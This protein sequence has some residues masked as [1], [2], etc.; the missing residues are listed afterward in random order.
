M[1]AVFPPAESF[2]DTRPAWNFSW[3]TPTRCRLI[4]ALVL[5]AGILGHINYLHHSPADLSGDEAQ[6]WDWSRN[7]D[8]SYYSKGPLVALIIRASTSIFGNTMPAVRYPA[9]A[10]GVATSIITYLLTKK[11]FNSE[12][13]ALG[14]VLLNHLV[15]MFI[16][17]SIL[18]TIDPPMFLCWALATYFAAIAL[19][20]N[21]N[22]PHAGGERSAAPG[23]SPY[24]P[25][26]LVGTAMGLGF[27]AKYAA[28]LWYLGLILFLILNHS[29]TRHLKGLLTAL[30]I[31][32]LFTTPVIIWNAQHHWVSLHHVAH[33]TGAAGGS[34]KKGN[35]LELIA[36]QIGVIGPILAVMMFAAILHTFRQ[37][38]PHS[39]PREGRGGVRGETS[40]DN[41]S[42]SSPNLPQLLYLTSL[43][44]TFLTLTLLISFFTKVQ[45][46]W[47]APAYFTLLILTAHF[48][49]TRLH[50][51]QTWRPWR[52]WFYG[53]IAMA[54]IATP[55]LHDPSL[56]FSP[57]RKTNTLLGTKID[58]AL[59]DVI[60]KL[61]GWQTLGNHL[62]TELAKHPD[63]II[64]TDDYMQAAE[65][66]FYTNGQP[67]TYYAGSYY[68]EAKRFTQYDMWPDRDL[69]RPELKG[70]TVIFL[71]KGGPFPPDIQNAFKEVKPL[72]DLDIIVRGVKVK[73]FRTWIC[74]NFKGMTRPSGPSSF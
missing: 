2:T 59:I 57:I 39:S 3:L 72:P 5:L 30:L 20:P 11:L 36:S 15:P 44:L 32:A 45:V 49:A 71:G 48:L 6:Y 60:Y 18:M 51:K 74:T 53:T 63:A 17:G 43:G 10:L 29:L 12:R 9:I 4:L 28:P 73:T 22:P 31:T 58:P 35:F 7:L 46:N 25:W 37:P 69:A 19:F 55:I 47:P 65:A 16:A 27:L 8:W 62:S 54:L 40:T 50:S 68:A 61:R 42:T 23:R 21:H 1:T 64:L 26:I 34:L 52:M 13:L 14:A 24:L 33:Q 66:A 41:P 70:K 67:K 38:K 56:L